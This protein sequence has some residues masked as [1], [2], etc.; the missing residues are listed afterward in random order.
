MSDIV[1]RLQAAAG[2]SY[3]ATTSQQGQQSTASA[4]VDMI[5]KYVDIKPLTDRFNTNAISQVVQKAIGSN[6]VGMDPKQLG[7]M[8]P[9]TQA[10]FPSSANN[11]NKVLNSTTNYDKNI[12]KSNDAMV[13]NVI[14]PSSNGGAVQETTTFVTKLAKENVEGFNLPSALTGLNL[15][16]LTSGALS[17]IANFAGLGSIVNSSQLSS[18]LSKITS[19]FS[20]LKDIANQFSNGFSGS[21]NTLFDN[22]SGNKYTNSSNSDGY[23]SSYENT[24][25]YEN[26]S[27]NDLKNKAPTMSGIDSVLN[28]LFN[29][30]N[31]KYP[32]VTDSSGGIF[33]NST[34]SYSELQQLQKLANEACGSDWNM[35]GYDNYGQN[36]NMYDLLLAMAGRNGLNGLLDS[37]MKCGNNAY[38]DSRS[39]DVL[40]SQIDTVARNGDVKTMLQIV[41]YSGRSRFTDPKSTLRTLA[42]NMRNTDEN[43]ILFT[44]LCDKFGYQP[45]D[46]VTSQYGY[47]NT[48]Y[49]SQVNNTSLLSRLLGEMDLAKTVQSVSALI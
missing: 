27:L 45:R 5:S 36:K 28:D 26:K 32:Q 3:K 16:S 7:S 11:L 30:T 12:G 37:L 41:E 10:L 17:R 4:A 19:N 21:N 1:E 23:G 9:D 40:S 29:S 49:T 14:A 22:I 25:Y 38:T 35:K 15:S 39:H 18:A 42:I 43:Y 24:S 13:K 31:K 20:N 34:T 8:L 33:G 46:I 2:A 47:V 44:Q 6:I 48:N